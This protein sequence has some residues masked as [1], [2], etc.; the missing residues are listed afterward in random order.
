MH[1]HLSVAAISSGSR[2][3]TRATSI[4]TLPSPMTTALVA[5][6]EYGVKKSG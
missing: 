2:T 4:A 1:N 3:I 5:A 6:S